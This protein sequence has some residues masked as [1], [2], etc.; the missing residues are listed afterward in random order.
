MP[1][2]KLGVATSESQGLTVVNAI[3]NHGCFVPP[4][5]GKSL[6]IVYGVR[7]TLHNSRTRHLPVLFTSSSASWNG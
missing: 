5:S 6:E 2:D 7:F 4:K 3:M 1:P